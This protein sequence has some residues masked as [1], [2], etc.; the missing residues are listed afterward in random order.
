[1]R[2]PLE[3]APDDR[4]TFE[5]FRDSIGHWCARRRDGL[6]NGT[7]FEREAALR[8]VR[9]ENLWHRGVDLSH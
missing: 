2:E 7:F 1:M 3:P 9:H 5:V 4:K 6:V 8:F